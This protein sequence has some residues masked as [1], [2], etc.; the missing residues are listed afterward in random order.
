M[1]TT[2]KGK[3]YEVYKELTKGHFFHAALSYFQLLFPDKADDME[4]FKE[5]VKNEMKL[6]DEQ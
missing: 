2:P 3:H 6:W 5:F 1:K 4:F